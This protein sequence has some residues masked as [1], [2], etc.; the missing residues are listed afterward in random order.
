MFSEALNEV[1]L[2][3]IDEALMWNPGNLVIGPLQ[4][5]RVNKYIKVVD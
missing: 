5:E 1:K 3:V 2:T 4:S